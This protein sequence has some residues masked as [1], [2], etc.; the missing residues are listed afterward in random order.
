MYCICLYTGSEPFI[1]R[2]EHECPKFRLLII[3]LT[4]TGKSTLINNLLGE[5][6]AEVGDDAW[7]KTDKIESFE[8]EVQGVPIVVYDSPGLEDNRKD[9]SYEACLAET[10][11]LIPSAHAVI[12]CFDLRQTRMMNAVTR[13]L[14]QYTEIGVDWSKTVFALTFADEIHIPTKV[15]KAP[16]SEQVKY[17]VDSVEK[18]KT[19]ISDVVGREIKAI[20]PTTG[21]SE[22]ELMTGEG[23]FH[24]FWLTVVKVLPPA[25]MV[26]FLE[27]YK[28]P[29]SDDDSPPPLK[30]Q[31]LTRPGIRENPDRK[32]F[33]IDDLNPSEQQELS[34]TLWKKMED[35]PDLI[36]GT[37]GGIVGL[38]LSLFL[39]IPAPFA[40]YTAAVGAN[41]VE[42]V[43]EGRKRKR[44]LSEREH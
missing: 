43:V 24:S 1:R 40:V 29:D 34:T 3:G 44:A 9:Q 23:W 17:F 6:V 22:E 33:Q 37:V 7:S 11:K 38:T 13:A 30:K 12:F 28:K 25:A 42:S 14:E 26:R 31:K 16:K 39:G 10:K 2:L 19:L 32:R 4:G 20:H 18:W 5:E 15:R 21:D 36:G 27:M 8:G 35:H 41:I